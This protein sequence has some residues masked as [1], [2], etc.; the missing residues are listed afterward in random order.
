MN[1][2]LELGQVRLVPHCDEWASEYAQEAV[3]LR[4]VLR[5]AALDIQHIGSTAVPG[6]PA[7]PILDLGVAIRSMAE[8]DALVPAL[9]ALG[10]ADMGEFGVPGRRFF[11]KGN[12]RTHHL[13]IVAQDSE[14]WSR[15]LLFRDYLRNCP[16]AAQHY[17]TMK[18][19]L[20]KR[21]AKN[22]EA[23]TAAKSKFIEGAVATASA[24]RIF[25]HS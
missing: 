23:Y 22:R 13:H 2:G 5:D 11:A 3:A 14:H 12:P 9:L 1:L 6:L 16:S 24:D 15:Y 7:K 20:A 18:Q 25:P 19:S 21:Y 8:V 17:S 4:R 10:Y